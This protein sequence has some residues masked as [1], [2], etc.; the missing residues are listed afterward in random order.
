MNMQRQ[1]TQNV[2]SRP[3]VLM[4]IGGQ[5]FEGDVGRV[6]DAMEMAHVVKL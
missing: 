6:T 2:L 1:W 4:R 5:M 3:R